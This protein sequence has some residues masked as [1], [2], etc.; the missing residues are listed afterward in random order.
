MEIMPTI[1]NPIIENERLSEKQ[2]IP[3]K[4]KLRLL[5]S[6]CIVKL[7]QCLTLF[8]L[9][10]LTILELIKPFTSNEDSEVSIFLKKIM[11]NKT[12]SRD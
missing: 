12:V 1:E 9:F 10:I 7:T 5:C 8:I 11:E 4:G 3:P 6:N 2:L